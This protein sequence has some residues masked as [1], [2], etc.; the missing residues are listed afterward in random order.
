M[1]Q[2]R[3]I[4]NSNLEALKTLAGMDGQGGK[5]FV[6]D[7][8]IEADRLGASDVHFEP[9]KNELKI[10]LRIDG[11]MHDLFEVP[12]KKENNI[13][14]RIKVMSGMDIT[15]KRLPQDGRIEI[16]DQENSLKL[17]VATIPQIFGEKVVM[18]IFSRNIGLLDLDSLGYTEETK[19][20]VE[21]MITRPA[22]MVI[23]SGPTGAGKTT[24]LY[25][26]MN[27]IK[28]D[29]KNI[30]SIEDP[31]EYII[32]GINQIQVNNA[33]DFTFGNILKAIM[34]QDPDIIAVGEIR[35]GETAHTATRA[36]LSGHLLLATFHANTTA[37]CISR[38]IDQGV[39]PFMAASAINGVL[40]QKL[41]KKICQMCIEE[42]PASKNILQGHRHFTGRGC[43]LCYNNG[44]KGRT[45]IQEALVVT[46]ELREV[47]QQNKGELPILQQAKKDGLKTLQDDAVRKVLEGIITYNEAVSASFDSL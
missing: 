35:D 25:A 33:I 12:K 34:R 41:A 42:A 17:R 47:I 28:A 22:G 7:L 45:G 15:E 3:R 27:K 29:H 6:R 30:I 24:T 39:L 2:N 36:A 1:K 40:V 19:K 31:I 9:G 5:D 13:I 8:V 11:T 20:K 44:T 37:K 21:Y 38:L 46:Q 26:A 43:R 18:R 16:E 23:V 14:S 32:E 4:T 10:R